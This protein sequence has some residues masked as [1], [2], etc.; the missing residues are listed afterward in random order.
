MASSSVPPQSAMSPAA[1]I[2][3][4]SPL[5]AWTVKLTGALLPTSPAAVACSAWAV[6]GPGVR[7][8][9]AATEKRLLV[10]WTADR[11][12]RGLPDTALPE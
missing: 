4:V 2:V 5:G 11:V 9:E 7:L 12:C 3:T 1:A 8:A 10:W 6:Y